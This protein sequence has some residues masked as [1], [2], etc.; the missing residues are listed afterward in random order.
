M[1]NLCGWTERMTKIDA[2]HASCFHVDHEVGEM[3]VSNTQNPVANTQQGMRA[4]E[5]GAQGK[6]CLRT[7]AHL[8]E[9]SPRSWK[10]EV[11][12]QVLTF[13][14]SFAFKRFFTYF[15]RSLGTCCNI[16]KKLLTVSARFASLAKNKHAWAHG[17]LIFHIWLKRDRDNQ[18]N[19]TESVIVIRF[20][21]RFMN[22]N[23]H[24]GDLLVNQTI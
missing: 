23:E 16:C 15:R 6:K 2:N 13:V 1:T 24:S 11:L 10:R 7:A 22:K 20:I 3:A 9:S 8:Q 4:D 19:F 21:Q 14:S 5:V 18:E 17:C 12:L